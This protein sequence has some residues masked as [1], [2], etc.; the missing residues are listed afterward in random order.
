[1]DQIYIAQ[2][3]SQSNTSQIPNKEPYFSFTGRKDRF[4]TRNVYSNMFIVALLA[5]NS[6]TNRQNCRQPVRGLLSSL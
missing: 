1:L 5:Y 6:F 4:I 3:G 2:H